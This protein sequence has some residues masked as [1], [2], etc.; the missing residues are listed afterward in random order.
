MKTTKGTIELKM[1][2]DT[3]VIAKCTW[4]GP[5]AIHK[6]P[7]KGGKFSTKDYVISNSSG[8]RILSLDGWLLRDIIPMV[9]ECLTKI[10]TENIVVDFRTWEQQAR[11]STVFT[12]MALKH[13]RLNSNAKN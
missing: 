3:N 7:K 5:I 10:E 1:F 13:L 9:E 12:E 4:I 6:Q 8:L 2:R 11:F